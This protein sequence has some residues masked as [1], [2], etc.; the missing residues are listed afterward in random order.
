VGQAGERGGSMGGKYNAAAIAAAAAAAADDEILHKAAQL[1]P[2]FT[3]KKDGNSGNR[4]K[5]NSKECFPL[6][7]TMVLLDIMATTDIMMTMPCKHENAGDI[8]AHLHGAAPRRRPVA[9]V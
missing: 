8:N 4:R 1:P 7:A 6:S 3:V 5:N 9:A 2:C